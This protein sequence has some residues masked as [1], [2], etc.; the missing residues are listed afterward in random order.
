M[1]PNAGENSLRR[2]RQFQLARGPSTALSPASRPPTPLRMTEQ[3]GRKNSPQNKTAGGPLLPFCSREMGAP[4]FAFFAKRGIPRSN[5]LGFPG[6]P[7]TRCPS[8]SH[9]TCTVKPYI[10]NEVNSFRCFSFFRGPRQGTGRA[11]AS[12]AQY[13][14]AVTRRKHHEYAAFELSP[15]RPKAAVGGR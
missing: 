10:L 13:H 11:T 7:S 8:T 9:L 4:C 3:S 1:F 6:F 5:P 14:L 15:Q 2:R 12:S